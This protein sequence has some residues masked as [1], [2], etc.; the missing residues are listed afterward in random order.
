LKITVLGALNFIV[1]QWFGVRLARAYYLARRGIR[2]ATVL[3]GG[4]ALSVGYDVEFVGRGW[5]VIRWVWPL[6][7]WWGGYRWIARSP[8]AP[9]IIGDRAYPLP[10]FFRRPGRAT[11]QLDAVAIA[12]M[13]AVSGLGLALLCAGGAP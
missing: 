5:C 12:G 3:P 7:G 4:G 2:H 6:T 8:L 11:G 1:L 9:V 10:A 13:V